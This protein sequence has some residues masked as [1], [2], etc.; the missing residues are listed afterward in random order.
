MGKRDEN[1]SYK[2]TKLYRTGLKFKPEK[3]FVELFK[4]NYMELLHKVPNHENDETISDERAKLFINYVC[5]AIT[6]CLDFGIN[7]WLNKTMIF[8]QKIADYK[9]MSIPEDGVK[10]IRFAPNYKH[11]TK[12]RK[13]LNKDNPEFQEYIQHKKEKFDEIK[14]YYREFYDK[15]E[16]WQGNQEG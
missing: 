11:I 2:M 10:K 15:P 16:W 6:F 13:E 7:V 9:G 4:Q 1:A 5:E 8:E 12:T 14:D 3:K